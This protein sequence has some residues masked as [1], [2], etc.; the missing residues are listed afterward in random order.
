MDNHIRKIIEVVRARQLLAV[1]LICLLLAFVALRRLSTKKRA[2]LPARDEILQRRY[3]RKEMLRGPS[4]GGKCHDLIRMS[5][6]SSSAKKRKSRKRKVEQQDEDLASMIMNSV[7]SVANAILEG[8]KII[9]ESNK[10]LE[11]AYRREYTCEEIYNELELMGLESH[12][13]PRTLN[14]LAANQAK[15]R[16]LFSCPPQIR[17]GL[18]RDMMGSGN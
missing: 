16:A 8:N 13:I 17:L 9:Q 2:N 14:Y 6:H 15:A 5:E 10:I 7:G 1:N 12:E 3:V 4:N 11:R 18:L